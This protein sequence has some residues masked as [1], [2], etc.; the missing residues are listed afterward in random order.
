MLAA[1]WEQ[2]GIVPPPGAAFGLYVYEPSRIGLGGESLTTSFATD[3]QLPTGAVDTGY[4]TNDVALW[5][6]F[7]DEPPEGEAVYLVG[8]DGEAQRWPA[9]LGACA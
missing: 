6:F 1:D 7:G 9:L 2:M 5:V 8:S 3:A 4:R